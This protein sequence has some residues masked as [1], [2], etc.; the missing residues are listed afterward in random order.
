M[1]ANG[2]K[3]FPHSLANAHNQ[4]NVNR[5]AFD[6]PVRLLKVLLVLINQVALTVEVLF[7]DLES[8]NQVVLKLSDLKRE[9]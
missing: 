2:I 9:Y 5:K 4:V 8:V 1:Y 6:M 3:A 7:P